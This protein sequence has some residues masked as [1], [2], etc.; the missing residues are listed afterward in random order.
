MFREL[1]ADVVTAAAH[2]MRSGRPSFQI[3]ALRGAASD[4]GADESAFA[5]RDAQ[6]S[7]VAFGSDAQRLDLMWEPRGRRSTG[8]YT[9][10]E[11][12]D[13]PARI[14]EAIPPSTLARLRRI[15]ERI[16]PRHLF[17]D[18]FPVGPGGDE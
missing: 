5:H 15:T 9:S 6:F 17:R 8:L 4:V 14:A 12:S 1:S 11:A 10:F 18:N 16:D 7:V 2:Q 13:R 3:R